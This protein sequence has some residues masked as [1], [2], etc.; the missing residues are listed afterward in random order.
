MTTETSSVTCAVI[1]ALRICPVG[2]GWLI[3]Y[4]GGL[5]ST[6]LLHAAHRVAQERGIS[7]HALHVNHQLSL[8]AEAWQAHCADQCSELD[9]EFRGVSVRVVNQGAGLEAAA[10]AA[11]Y[12]V[13]IEQLGEEEQLLLAHH[14][15]DQAETLLLRLM[16]GAGPAGLGAMQEQRSLGAGTLRR[17]LLGL[18]R[19]DLETYAS[20]HKLSWVEDDS[21]ASLDFDRNFLRHQV[22]PQLEQRWPGFTQRWQQSASLCQ[23]SAAAD[24]Q[25]G[26]AD[27]AACQ[28]VPASWGWS[29][30][31]AGLQVLSAY[32]RGN[33]LRHWLKTL[34]LAAPEQK[35]L[36][37]VESQLLEARVDAKS[38]V[39]WGAGDERVRLCVYRQRLYALPD[40]KV[41]PLPS[42]VSWCIDEPLKWGPWSLTAESVSEGDVGIALPSLVIV[43]SRAGGERC[44]PVGR[45]H[46]QSLKKL[47]QEYA[48]EPWLRDQLPLIFIDGCLAA[49]ADRWV[50]DGFVEA[51]TPVYRLRWQR[52]ANS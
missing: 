28:P 1:A 31:L 26:A 50:C 19:A 45:G 25:R 27:L 52:G 9:R 30:S 7:L 17:P 24:E 34:G 36:Q 42:E 37:Q 16:R 18:S 46:T 2:E 47:L 49:V 6:V 5:D 11:R 21:N 14:Q 20:T 48:V 12:R 3:A 41:D 43:K 32:Q 15:D 39:S 22:M 4:S 29:I 33:L 51:Q 13:F 40:S 44:K 38:Q 23:Q 10:R 8:N 35:H